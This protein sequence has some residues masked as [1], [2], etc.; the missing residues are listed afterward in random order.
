M[1]NRNLK[2][3]P[4]QLDP[5]PEQKGC[6]F[7]KLVSEP[8]KRPV[9]GVLHQTLEVSLRELHRRWLDGADGAPT[10]INPRGCLWMS[11]DPHTLGT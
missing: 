8:P 1:T 6:P 11:M 4:F 3:I 7:P 9:Q 2:S 10:G 5:L